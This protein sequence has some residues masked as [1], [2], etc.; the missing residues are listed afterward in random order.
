MI[1]KADILRVV[2]DPK[3]S[4]SCTPI[5]EEPKKPSFAKHQSLAFIGS[6][7]DKTGGQAKIFKAL[8]ITRET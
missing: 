5:G 2:F 4:F 3:K 1:E 8:S 7:E 6:A